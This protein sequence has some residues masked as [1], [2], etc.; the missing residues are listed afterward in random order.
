[1]IAIVHAERPR[2]ICPTNQF[3]TPC[4]QDP[5]RIC[6][7]FHPPDVVISVIRLCGVAELFKRELCGA[8]T[9]RSLLHKMHFVSVSHPPMLGPPLSYPL[10]Y[11]LV[12]A[13]TKRPHHCSVLSGSGSPL[14]SRLFGDR[15]YPW[16]PVEPHPPTDN[17]T[18]TT[19]SR[20]CLRS[21]H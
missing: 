20:R 13:L 14:F 1:M 11:V 16:P 4:R 12:F 7:F 10:H 17:A 3:I 15:L 9:E 5:L 18:H 2:H 21:P 6:L 19:C 8:I